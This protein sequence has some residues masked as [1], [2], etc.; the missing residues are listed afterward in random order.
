MDTPTKVVN[1]H[2]HRGMAEKKVIELAIGRILRLGSRPA[3][4]GDVAE[5]ERCRALILDAAERQGI[6]PSG[7]NIGTHRPGWNYGNHSLD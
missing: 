5:Y 2:S 1:H 7:S 6:T 3:R 4:P